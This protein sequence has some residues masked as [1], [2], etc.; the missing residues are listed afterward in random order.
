[1]L[2]KIYKSHLLYIAYVYFLSCN[3]YGSTFDTDIK[4]LRAR[5]VLSEYIPMSTLISSDKS[6]QVLSPVKKNSIAIDIA[7]SFF[8]SIYDEEGEKLLIDIPQKIA[9]FFDVNFIYGFKDTTE[10]PVIILVDVKFS[11]KGGRPYYPSSFY[12][13]LWLISKFNALTDAAATDSELASFIDE[14]DLINIEKSLLGKLILRTASVVN[15]D[16]TLHMYVFDNQVPRLEENN[17]FLSNVL[18]STQDEADQE[19]KEPFE[20]QIDQFLIRKIAQ[21]VI[22]KK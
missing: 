21:I 15:P 3:I 5:E 7:K 8:E 4:V 20:A 16:E 18:S 12:S 14:Y 9:H 2:K 22:E 13:D 17:L 11:S 1:M 10:H 19:S 6:S